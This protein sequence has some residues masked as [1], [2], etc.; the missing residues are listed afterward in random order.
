M[1]SISCDFFFYSLIGSICHRCRLCSDTP[2]PHLVFG[3]F[4]MIAAL[5]WPPHP[6]SPYVCLCSQ[7]FGGI[8]IWCSL[9]PP[10]IQSE[11]IKRSLSQAWL[12]VLIWAWFVCCLG[13]LPKKTW[14]KWTLVCGFSQISYNVFQASGR[15]DNTLKKKMCSWNHGFESLECKQPQHLSGAN[16]GPI[17]CPPQKVSTPFFLKGC[18]FNRERNVT[19]NA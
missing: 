15:V 16:D 19:T 12:N 2:V 11:Q 5:L 6:P 9:K 18:I 17:R 14:R 13:G 3:L 1:Q 4:C 8:F 10:K 7:F